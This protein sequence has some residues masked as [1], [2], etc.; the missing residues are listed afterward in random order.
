MV[1]RIAFYDPNPT[2]ASMIQR[3][4]AVDPRR[5]MADALLRSGLDSSPVNSIAEGLARLAKAGTGAYQNY[6]LRQEYDDR[7]KR[8][9]EDMMKAL[10][11]AEAKPW[12]NPDTGTNMVPQQL[13]QG[14]QGPMVPTGPAGGMAGMKA[15]LMGS[16]N[17][18]LAPMLQQ[19]TMQ[20]I[21]AQEAARQAEAARRAGIEDYRTKKTIDQEFKDP[22]KPMSVAPGN[23]LYDPTKGEAIY[24]APDNKDRKTEKDHAGILRYTDTGEPVFDPAVV[25]DVKMDPEKVFDQETKLRKEF[26]T[27]T[28]DFV[29]VRDAFSRIDASAKDP[30]PAGDLALIFNYMKVLDPG[31]TVREGEFATAQNSAGVPDRLRA[32]Y[33]QITKGERLAPEQRQDFL[34]RAGKLYESQLNQYQGLEERYRGLAEMYKLNPEAVVYGMGDKTPKRG[35]EPKLPVGITAAPPGSGVD[36]M[37]TPEAPVGPAQRGNDITRY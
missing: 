2:Q 27:Q 19:I 26:T 5:D 14:M 23:T 31:S 37:W 17:P 1:N 16:N 18:D 29:K 21:A 30:S 4:F 10:A 28:D 24:T 13:P 25:G 8:Y 32:Q 34:T 22:D 35:E 20:Q 9:G 33:N 6:S 3:D 11:G 15:A 7:K 36:Y 12:V